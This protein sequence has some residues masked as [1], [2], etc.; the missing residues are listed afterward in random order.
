MT[1]GEQRDEVT[2]SRDGKV[3]RIMDHTSQQQLQ[4]RGKRRQSRQ[5]RHYSQRQSSEER[6]AKSSPMERETFIPTRDSDVSEREAVIDASAYYHDDYLSKHQSPALY[7]SYHTQNTQNSTCNQHHS[8]D[9]YS[10]NGS[11]KSKQSFLSRA[12]KQLRKKMAKELLSEVSYRNDDQ[13]QVREARDPSP[14]NEVKSSSIALNSNSDRNI[15]NNGRKREGLRGGEWVYSGSPGGRAEAFHGLIQAFPS[16]EEFSSGSTIS[17][18]STNKLGEFIDIAPMMTQMKSKMAMSPIM[19]KDYHNHRG[20]RQENIITVQMK[21]LTGRHLVTKDEEIKK[22]RETAQNA[23]REKEEVQKQSKEVSPPKTLSRN[24]HERSQMNETSSTSKTTV[25]TA[26]FQNSI[27]STENRQHAAHARRNAELER[28][29]DDL[30]KKLAQQEKEMKNEALQLSEELRKQKQKTEDIQEEANVKI[31]EYEAYKGACSVYREKLLQ[32]ERE[33]AKTEQAL[34]NE[35]RKVLSLESENEKLIS[36]AEEK[37]GNAVTLEKAKTTELKN[38]MDQCEKYRDRVLELERKLMS[39]EG[40]LTA[41]NAIAKTL[42]EEKKT[43]SSELNQA[44]ASNV[45][46]KSK[47]SD[48]DAEISSLQSDASNLESK[49]SKLE[50]ALKDIKS[51]AEDDKQTIVVLE[52]ENACL[53]AQLKEKSLVIENLQKYAD[54]YKR[55]EDENASLKRNNDEL[56]ANDLQIKEEL[57]KSEVFS[58]NTGK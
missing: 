20:N 12:S 3:P 43:L 5:Q 14:T 57:C 41:T 23:I 1:G 50:A 38:Y 53:L 8:H 11:N 4:H 48:K 56:V 29:V 9:G 37:I 46:F 49:N 51:K 33:N 13:G 18:A 35:R 31:N 55:I 22:L 10:D 19:E 32:K 45:T 39:V 6:Q 40:T 26:S 21:E 30:R 16:L 24:T 52:D 44:K 15:N 7:T 58:T 28:E 36:V 2:R 54:Q 25:L 27:A 42:E 47:I 34:Y 17:T